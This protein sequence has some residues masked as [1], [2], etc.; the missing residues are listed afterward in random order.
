MEN[1]LTRIHWTTE[2]RFEELT[3]DG[4]KNSLTLA[5]GEGVTRSLPVTWIANGGWTELTVPGAP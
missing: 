3:P 2:H 5:T 4:D 1:L